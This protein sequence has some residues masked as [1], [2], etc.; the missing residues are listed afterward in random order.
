MKQVEA[1]QLAI[2]RHS[3]SKLAVFASLDRGAWRRLEGPS[4]PASPVGP[5]PKKSAGGSAPPPKKKRAGG[6]APPLK[7]QESG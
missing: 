6:R 4:L 1:R 2:S 3:C 5:P 7:L